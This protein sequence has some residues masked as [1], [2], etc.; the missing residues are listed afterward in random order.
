MRPAYGAESEYGRLRRVLLHAPT[1]AEL[2]PVIAE[3]PAKWLF[4][5]RPYVGKLL[6]EYE[7]FID[8]LRAE[9]VELIFVE[10]AGTPNQLYVRDA[11]LVTRL[12]AVIGNFRHQVRR[13]EEEPIIRKL[14]ELGIP[15]VLR[16]RDD[17]HFEGGDAI[18][19]DDELWVGYG[20]RTNL[21]G[22]Q[23]L[24]KTLEGKVVRRVRPL[25]LRERGWLIHLDQ[26]LG[27]VSPSICLIYKDALPPE[28]VRLLEAKGFEL[29]E[30][31]EEEAK[32]MAANVLAIDEGK[33]ILAD[34]YDMNRRTRRAL[35]SRGVDVIAV[36]MRELIKGNGGP[37]CMSLPLLREPP[38]AAGR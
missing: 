25:R 31:P 36:P 37:R 28:A 29:I 32:T 13:G 17:A 10:G 20:V 12:G 5:E 4:R 18:F 21:R 15:I 11:G 27:V 24:K 2:G 1:T 23:E 30:I 22:I 33:V 9:G 34:G 16:M 38:R 26:A 3:D 14:S 8:A 35:E 7:E 19:V 6:R